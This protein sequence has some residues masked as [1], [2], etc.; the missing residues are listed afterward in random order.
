LGEHTET[1]LQSIGLSA[2]QIKALKEAG[3][4]H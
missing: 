1:V 2:E 3:V 4:L